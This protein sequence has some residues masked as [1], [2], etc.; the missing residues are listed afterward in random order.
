MRRRW[1]LGSALLGALAVAPS[2]HAQQAQLSQA[3]SVVRLPAPGI[4]RADLD[5]TCA[6]C[7]D[8]FTFATGGWMKRN[9]IPAAYAS[10]GTLR[11]LTDQNQAIL[12]RVLDSAALEVRSGTAKAGTNRYRIGA[13]YSACM[14]TAAI[15]RL[16]LT[17]I[18]KGLSEIDGIFTRDDL[19]R[20]IAELQVSD[21]I[22]PFS[23]T[24]TADAKNSNE[25]ILGARQGGLVLPD[26]DYYLKDDAD[27]AR[28]RA[29]YVTHVSKMLQLLG[30]SPTV[31]DARARRVLATETKL[32][33]AS[34]DNI[35]RREPN[36]TYHKMTL[37]D[38]EAMTPNLRWAD[39]LA[40]QHAPR[41]TEVNVAQPV[42][43]KTLD[44]YVVAITLDDWKTLLRWHLLNAHASQLPRRFALEDFQFNTFRTGA[45]MQ[46]PRW[47]DCVQATDRALGEA[48]G[49]EYVQRTFSPAAKARATTI[50]DNVVSVLRDQIGQL[51]WMGPDTK[52]QAVMKLDAVTRMIGYPDH[53]RDY[54]A[55]VVKPGEAIGNDRRVR[56][57]NAA[58]DWSKI[59]K[60]ADKADWG[61][62]PPT[63]NAYY[64]PTVNE[65][66]FP[67][68]ILQSPIFD[69]SADDAVN[70]GAMGAI[71]GHEMTHGFD[72]TGRQ[73]D[74]QGNLRDWW[75]KDDA[76]KFNVEAQKIIDQFSA[77]TIVDSLTHVNGKLTEGENIADLGGVK[78]AYLAMERSFKAKGHPAPIDGFSAEQ[79]FFLGWAQVWRSLQRTEAARLQVATNEHAPSIWRVNGP[80]SNMPEFKAA[81][82]C[83]DGDPMVRPDALRV[84]IW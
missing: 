20:V 70:Y 63:V 37:A 17:P 44:E 6:A 22:A 54:S 81:W 27:K 68:G 53:W 31:A 41:I 30:D 14:D 47:Q 23:V 55:L 21:G 69:P 60:P 58:R 66:V 61:M 80:L 50:V 12:H 38:F 57:F 11:E 25:T 64:S 1:S 3:V 65:I 39:Y 78:I 51:D 34:M 28:I 7:T 52:R 45:T 15:E 75:T 32:A 72:N 67:A 26:R 36:A 84:R 73:Y 79:R 10:Y 82:G 33:Q 49:Q 83:K 59:G 19:A 4:N 62:T 2:G 29:D 16:G 18:A 48:L 46:Q 71:I 40:T 42:F 9:T 5:T 13:F 76:D 8:F 74:A 35:T 56:A 43:F 77:Y 24:P